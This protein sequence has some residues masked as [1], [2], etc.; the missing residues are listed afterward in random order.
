MHEIKDPS[1]VVCLVVDNGLFI[2]LAL[3]LSKKYK[4][5]FYYC[6][7]ES[8]F[9]KMNSRVAPLPSPTWECMAPKSSRQS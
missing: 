6:P 1:D 7:W 9:A 8:A 5:V 3:K 4:K 2:E